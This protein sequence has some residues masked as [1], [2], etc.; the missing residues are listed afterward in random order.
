[1][2]RI[3]D[4][5]KGKTLAIACPKLDD[6]KDIYLDKLV[7]YG[8]RLPGTTE[9][10]IERQK[11]MATAIIEKQDRILAHDLVAVWV[12]DLDP[13]KMVGKQKD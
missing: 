4:I 10:G 3:Q 13:D 2:S 9:D 8:N 7:A 6:G 11:L 12:R 5:L 1:M